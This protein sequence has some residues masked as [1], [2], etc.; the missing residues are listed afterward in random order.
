[1][2]NTTVT[3]ITE[4]TL[5]DQ[6]AHRDFRSE[7]LVA[8][9]AAHQW[10]GDLLTCKHWAHA[11]LNEGFATY[12]DALFQE[13]SLGKDE[14]QYTMLTN[15]ETYFEE[16]STKYRRAIVTNIYE[17]PIDLFDRHLYPGGAWR[18]HMIRYL[19]GEEQF[20]TIIKTYL[21]EYQFKV[22]ETIDFQ[23]TIEKVTGRSFEEFFDQFIYKA[24]YPIYKIQYS[25]NA[26][27]K[28]ILLKVE[29][30]QKDD[31]FSLTPIFKMP[32]D[33]C[34]V[35][36]SSQKVVRI[37]VDQREQQFL[38]SVDTKPLFVRF[39]PEN[40]LLKKLE[41]QTESE[42]LISQL[43]KDT[44]IIGRIE[45]AKALSKKPSA[46][47]I[48]ILG[49]QLR[50]DPFW[51]V[52]QNI[53]LALGTIGGELALE[54]LLQSLKLSHP[55]A[56]RKVVEVL[57]E[58][59]DPRAVEALISVLQIGDESYFVE[60]SAAKALGKTKATKA[61]EILK[62][63]LQ[64]SSYLDVIREGV[65]LGLSYLKDER[66]LDIAIEWIQK[67]KPLYA[68]L[69]AFSALAELGKLFNKQKAFEAVRTELITTEHFRI[70]LAAM[71]ALEALEMPESTYLLRKYQETEVDG[72]LKRRA[73]NAIQAIT[74]NLEKPKELN[75]LREEI[76]ILRQSNNELKNELY[77]I[78]DK[79]G[80][81]K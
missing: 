69:A 24:G 45:A 46:K 1:M 42:Y 29:Q 27:N 51:G 35:F 10:F 77:I 23:R 72:R 59:I 53:A 62:A 7:G 71:Q 12:F 79:L 31:S 5:H 56:R 48:K 43:Q 20:R 50:N 11:W 32:V 66:G 2:E 44:S 64:K 40:W 60:G 73:F 54:E 25:W 38:I 18:L 67:G 21:E 65:F 74:R 70:K 63:Q 4:S 75:E 39:D 30:V 19:V 6:R 37:N 47:I 8:H 55:K 16:D 61:F 81:K 57:G 49:E 68:R 13:Y 78:Q 15:V 80:L 26:D 34:I 22:V 76:A 17:E 28:S 14:F 9:E 58:F 52:Q 36:E 41:I 33:I 3:T